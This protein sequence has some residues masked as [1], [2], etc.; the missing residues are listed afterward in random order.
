MLLA[1][2]ESYLE[3]ES[4]GQVMGKFIQGQVHYALYI[5]HS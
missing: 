1:Q 2:P 5:I 3:A 4:D